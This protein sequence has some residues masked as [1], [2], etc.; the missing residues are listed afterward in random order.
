MNRIAAAVPA[1]DLGMGLFKSSLFAIAIAVISCQQ[2]LA[3][4]GGA[5]EVGRRT[6]GAVVGILFSLILIDAVFAVAVG[7]MGR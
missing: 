4:S 6:T 5:S 7:A 2:G 3:T 1:W